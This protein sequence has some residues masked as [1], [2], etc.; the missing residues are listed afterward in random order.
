VVEGP[1]ERLDAGRGLTVKDIK[2]AKDLAQDDRNLN[3][4]TKRGRDL[5]EKSLRRYGA[6][7]SILADKDGNVVAGNKT[8]K[9]AADLGLPVRVIQTDG[10]ELVVVQRTDLDLASKAGRELA[11]A[12]NR[13]AE[14]DLEWDGEA[15]AELASEGVDVGEFFLPEELADLPGFEGEEKPPPSAEPQMGGMEYRIIIECQSEAHQAD[16][17]RRFEAEGLR[18]KAL[19]S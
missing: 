18:V 5:L 1:A 15:L 16:L 4:G 6:G 13:V 3:R 14:L 9:A 11:L 12:D 10:K 7:R 8:L 17:L 19:I 2:D